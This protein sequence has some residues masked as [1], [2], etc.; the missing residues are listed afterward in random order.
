[1][2]LEMLAG[3]PLA[4]EAASGGAFALVYGV[5]SRM[6]VVPAIEKLGTQITELTGEIR[7]FMKACPPFEHYRTAPLPF[8]APKTADSAS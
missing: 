1:M 7:G 3:I 8:P 2:T 4:G 6:V 5:V